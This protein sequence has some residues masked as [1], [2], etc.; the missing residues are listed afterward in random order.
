M[1]QKAM[2]SQMQQFG[3]D[4][5]KVMTDSATRMVELAGVEKLEKQGVARA[6]SAVDEASRLAKE[7]ITS[8]EQ[9]N[10]QWRKA[11][12]ELTQRTLD[13]ITPAH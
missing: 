9:L 11:A 4:W 6:V 12:T 2:F 8:F 7:A 1:D 5:L 3:A 13:L 10:H